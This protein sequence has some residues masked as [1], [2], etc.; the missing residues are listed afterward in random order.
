ML[1]PHI[2]GPEPRFPYCATGRPD[3]PL[4]DS[5]YSAS[6]GPGVACWGLSDSAMGVPDY[7]GFI[8]VLI[9]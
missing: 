8:F 7:R 5:R 4:R 2:K 6:R 1:G 3:Q 9:T